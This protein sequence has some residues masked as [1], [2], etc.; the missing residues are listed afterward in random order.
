MIK[1]D[2]DILSEYYQYELSYLRSAGSDFAKR[3]PK[4]ARR[5]DLSHNESTDPHVE[6]LIE[7]VAFLT[8]KLQKQ[9]DDQFPEIANALL[10]VLYEPLILPTPS[11]VM[12]KFE[13]DQSR[14]MKTPGIVVPK[15]TLLHAKS[16]SGETCSFMTAHDLQLWPIEIS[17]VSVIQ[18]E[19]LPNYFAHS[20]YYLKIGIKYNQ[21]NSV[22]RKL[23][24]YMHADAL[25][26]GKFFSSIFSTE[27]KVIFQKDSQYKSISTISP[28]GVED[29]ESLFPY[30]QTIHSGFRLLQEYFAFA[31][32]FYGFDVELS[33][34][35][36]IVGESFLY[37][38]MSYD[39]AM[40]ISVKNLSLSSVPA[41]NLFPKVTEPLRLDH[42]Q[43]EYCL[44]SDYRRYNSNEI[45][46][47]KK[48]VA[49]DS[50]NNDEIFIPEFFSCDYSLDDANVGIFW[51]SRRKKSYMKDAVGDDVYLSFI[52][53]NFNPQYPADKIFYG[54]TLCTNRSIAEQIPVSG[55]LQIE[56]SVPTKKIYCIDRP[57]PQKPSIKSGEV[58]WKLI[59]ALSL[60]SISFSED[61]IKKIRDILRVFA[62][63]SGS[64]LE[65]EV[66]AIASIDSFIT[67]RRFDEQ[68]WRGFVRGAD[69][70]ITFDD[71][72]QNLGLPLSLVLSK[73]LSSYTSINTFTD[74]I[75][76]NTSKNGILKKW[77][78]QFGIKNYL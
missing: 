24:F 59:S 3:F 62:D 74:V 22:P 21:A 44:V 17:T 77:K 26:R 69:I 35:L 8:G 15:D 12:V 32:K 29:H 36:D 63:I 41:V 34:N 4:I 67:T 2:T 6:R 73:F 50:K 7:S 27:E 56:L 5:L 48:I 53:M 54:H 64:I 46:S 58:L 37:V 14:A 16:N 10:G 66:D 18:K 65:R 76:K 1:S 61:G 33:E 28:V 40:Q 25:L 42:K 68:T 31:D 52:D 78:Q 23:R 39:I 11:C 70:E 19:H 60:N 38:P 43:V 49:V 75:V 47:V 57:T 51:K 45:Y 72:I 71:R 20:T 55:E 13:I 30:P 9:I